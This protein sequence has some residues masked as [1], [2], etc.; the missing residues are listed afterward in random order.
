[1]A[2]VESEQIFKEGETIHPKLNP[3]LKMVIRRYMDRI[4][5]CQDPEDPSRKEF[6]FFERE[7]SASI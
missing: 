6:A 1:M 4:Y 2:R 3:A 5:Y 7:I